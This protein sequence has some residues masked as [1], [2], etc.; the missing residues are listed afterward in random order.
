MTKLEINDYQCSLHARRNLWQAS[1]KHQLELGLLVL[2]NIFLSA[3]HGRLHKVMVGRRRFA[4][5]L[6]HPP[7]AIHCCNNL[8]DRIEEIL[9]IKCHVKKL[10]RKKQWHKETKI[11]R[12]SNQASPICI[13]PTR[14]QAG[15]WQKLTKY[16]L[17]RPWMPTFHNSESITSKKTDK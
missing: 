17:C 5:N 8:G 12:A 4:C 1:K 14:P 11:P 2:A 13:C 3:L 7:D 15:P 16:R 10:L 9:E 6:M